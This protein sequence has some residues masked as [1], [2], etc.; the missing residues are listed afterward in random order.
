MGPV[1]TIINEH[2]HFYVQSH[3][4]LIE[5]FFA[6]G[7][8]KPTP[9]QRLKMQGNQGLEALATLCNSAR[10]SNEEHSPTN[11]EREI[12]QHQRIP[13]VPAVHAE[14]TSNGI[15]YTSPPVP[16]PQVHPNQSFNGLPQNVAAILKAMG[17][18]FNHHQLA[19]ML[20]SGLGGGNDNTNALQQLAYMNSLQNA[21]PSVLQIMSQA[22]QSAQPNYFFAGMDPNAVNALLLAAQ[23]RQ[24]GKNFHAHFSKLTLNR[25][26]SV[27]DM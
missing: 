9:H 21:Q 11:N 10:M 14:F 12:Y 18:N 26:I 25:C 20:S 6:F 27:C 5:I 22:T 3:H 4:L 15:G 24:G 19:N 13:P 2:V 23:T 7:N 17:T 1:I 8:T 16:A